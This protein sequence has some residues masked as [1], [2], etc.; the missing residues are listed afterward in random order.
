MGSSGLLQNH[1]V[2]EYPFGSAVLK[3]NEDECNIAQTGFGNVGFKCS[4]T[5]T[6]C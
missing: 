6:V 4:P 1:A 5:H 2:R 3:R